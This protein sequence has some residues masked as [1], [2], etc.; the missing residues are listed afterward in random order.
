[1]M[2]ILNSNNG[3]QSVNIDGRSTENQQIIANAFNKHFTTISN[4]INKNINAN[5][6]LTKTAVNNQNMLSYSL[7]YAF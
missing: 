3:M 4:M 7:I 5:Y 2:N 6:C 1:M